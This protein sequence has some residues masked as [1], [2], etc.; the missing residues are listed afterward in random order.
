M[1]EDP[2]TSS[3]AAAVSPAGDRLR[4]FA[5]MQDGK[6]RMAHPLLNLTKLL[7]NHTML[8]K[9]PIAI[10]S[11]G[12]ANMKLRKPAMCARLLLTLCAAARISALYGL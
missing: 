2:H 6:T 12:V 8:R 1:G 11:I 9:A 10:S 4:N 3:K 5:L 7:N